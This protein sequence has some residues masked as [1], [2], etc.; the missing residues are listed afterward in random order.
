MAQMHYMFRILILG[1]KNLICDFME[2]SNLEL[3][4]KDVEVSHYSKRIKTLDGN[5]CD[6]EIEAIIT[7]A[8]DYDTLIPTCDG[9]IYLINPNKIEEI[10]LFELI[11][12]IINELERE[13]PIIVIFYSSNGFCKIPSNFLLEYIWKKTYYESYIFSNFSN[14]K[15]NVVLE[16]IADAII[17]GSK[18]INIETAWLRIPI[19]IEKINLLVL[20][21]RWKEAAKYS[22]IL[23]EIKKKFNL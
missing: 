21:E 8:I 4:S 22:E 12:G 20:Q 15:I 6:L 1:N 9:I 7:D 16:C 17:S 5:I 11:S 2:K 23:T 14:I 3:L 10:E 18:P 13:F 19:L